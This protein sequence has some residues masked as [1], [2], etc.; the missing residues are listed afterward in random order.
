MLYSER[1]EGFMKVFEIIN[2]LNKGAKMEDVSANLGISRNT[3]YRHL[4]KGHY[5]Y[6]NKKK[7]V[8]FIGEAEDKQEIDG[9]EFKDLNKR[10]SKPVQKS[11]TP[12]NSKDIEDTRG[13]HSKYT[14]AAQEIYS[15]SEEDA[16]DSLDVFPLTKEE[17]LQL[18]ALLATPNIQKQD[19]ESN[20]IYTEISLL[21][22]RSKV[23]KYTVEIDEHIYNDF[24][25]LAKKL[26]NKR[27]GKA[28]L[29]EI[30][31]A[32]LIRDFT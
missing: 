4:K 18:R 28:T 14:A 12:S 16:Q 10:T 29:V 3:L 17:V 5:V 7:K 26:S 8:I 27:I 20:S 15:E 31:L 11:I 24:D 1:S 32:R 21:P 9:M 22:D 25:E 19:G 2:S 30:A 13:L 6:D 23:K